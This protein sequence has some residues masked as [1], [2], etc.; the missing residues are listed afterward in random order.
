MKF[1]VKQRLVSMGDDFDIRD[2]NGKKKFFVDGLAFSFM[3]NLVI[4]DMNKQEQL[5]IKRKMFTFF[6]TYLVLKKGQVLA[7]VKKRPFTLRTRFQLDIP[8][9]GT[10]EVVGNMF[11]YDYVINRDGQEVAK[12]SKKILAFS[13]S[14]GVDISENENPLVMLAVAIVIDIV[15]HKGK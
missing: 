5:R 14:Y 11:R 12:V 4:K 1:A 15:L 7:S 9:P 6:P 2:E 3:E 8:G 13:D 10:Y